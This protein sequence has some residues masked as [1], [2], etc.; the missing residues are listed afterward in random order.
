MIENIDDNFGGMM[1]KLEEWKALENTLVIF[2]TD[3]GMSMGQIKI[4]GS[5][6]K[7]LEEKG[8]PE[9]SPSALQ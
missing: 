9:W 2:M 4:K 3:N 6:N 1:K 5:Q 7:Q 8:I